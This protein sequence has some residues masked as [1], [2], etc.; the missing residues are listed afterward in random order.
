MQ[1][2][3]FYEACITYNI[4]VEF[5]RIGKVVYPYSISQR[6][7]KEEGFDF[8]YLF[9]E[10]AFLIQYKRPQALKEI[11]DGKKIY[12]WKI[13]REQLETLNR[14]SKGI[15]IYYALPAFEDVYDWYSGIEQTYFIDSRRLEELY[16]KE[17]KTN[18][19]RSDCISLRNWEF[20]FEKFKKNNY[21]YAIPKLENPI[22]LSFELCELT[23]GL[24]AYC[25]KEKR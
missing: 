3:K 19:F 11:K 6:E 24:W 2:E 21:N 22:D 7:E 16:D 4:I 9:D 18:I 13:E 5:K 8:G 10:V 1:P 25:V 17:K 15:P 20:I 23:D 14:N 12:S